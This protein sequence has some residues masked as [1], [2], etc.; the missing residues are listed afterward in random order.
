MVQG[1]EDL[2]FRDLGFRDSGLRVWGI[3]LVALNSSEI[4]LSLRVFPYI[5]TAHKC[6]YRCIYLCMY[7]YM[8][9]NYNLH[10]N[11]LNSEMFPPADTVPA[12]AIHTA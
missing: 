12:L 11:R 1:F 10:A 3:K 7:V 2:E 8:V 4:A 9:D 5:Y 6:V